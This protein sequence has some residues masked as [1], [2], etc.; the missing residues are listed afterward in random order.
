MTNP[1]AHLAHNQ[2][3]ENNKVVIYQQLNKLG[4]LSQTVLEIGSGTGQQGIHFCS[5]KSELTWQPSEVSDN[6]QNLTQWHKVAKKVGI[7]NFLEP[8]SFSIGDEL[9]SKEG[10]DSIYTSNVLHIVSNLQAKVLVETV[11][12][13]LKLGQLFICYGPFKKDGRFTTSSNE[14]FNSW[15]QE[16]GY[17]GLVDLQ[18]VIGWSKNKLRIKHLCD[19]PAN[20][21]LVVF[22]KCEA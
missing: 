12:L 6:L 5:N 18:D 10:F 22:E 11:T 8:I 1:F 9:L 3:A 19:M 21:F 15:L 16:Q 4:L 17:G 20:N 14:Q 2:A 13:S 7:S